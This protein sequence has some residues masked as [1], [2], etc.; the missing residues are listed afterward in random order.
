M[1]KIQDE[2]NRFYKTTIEKEASNAE[3][4]N[5]KNEYA[6]RIR[7]AQLIRLLPDNKTQ[8]FKVA[9]LGCGLGDLSK[10]IS[11]SGYDNF[12]YIGYDISPEMILSAK[13]TFETEKISFRLTENSQQT[14]KSDYYLA[15]GIFNKKLDTKEYE[16]IAY[17]LETLQNM[18]E[19]S[20]KGFAFNMLTSY[21]DADKQRADLYYANPA[22]F[23]D[24]CKRNF[25]RNVALLHDYNEYDFTILVRK[26]F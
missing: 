16:W 15:S 8:A 18:H 1:K 13:N 20:E 26:N 3:K 2:M 24:Y 9:D 17:I 11:E 19:K 10:F 7:F 14:E 22:Y 21:S 12:S 5:W 25:S 4:V 23:F 6:Q